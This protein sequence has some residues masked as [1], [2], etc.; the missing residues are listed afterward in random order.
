MV[1]MIA[2]WDFLFQ[3]G[4]PFTMAFSVIEL[5]LTDS[6]YIQISEEPKKYLLY[7]ETKGKPIFAKLG[8]DGWEYHEQMGNGHFFTRGNEQ[9]HIK[10]RLWTERYLVMVIEK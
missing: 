6:D 10:E 4:S 3:E 1:F 2:F 7:S 5:E 8:Q 9:L